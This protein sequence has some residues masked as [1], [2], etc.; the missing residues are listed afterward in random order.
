MNPK[1]TLALFNYCQAKYLPDSISAIISQTDPPDEILVFDDASTDNSINLLKEIPSAKFYF[2]KVNCGLNSNIKKS[3][4]IAEGDFIVFIAADDLIYPNFIKE[5]RNI[6]K[7]FSN[8]G[9]ICSDCV[10]FDDKLPYKY[11]IFRFLPFV[12]PQIFSPKESIDLFRKT[13]FSLLSHTCIY[14]RALLK[15]F[16]GYDDKLMSLADFFLNTQIALRYPIAY[17]PSPSA[18][19]RVVQNS[20]GQSFR[21]SWEKRKKI[22]ERLFELVYI[23]SDSEFRKAFHRARLMS[24]VGMYAIYYVICNPK[25]WFCLP[26]LLIKNWKLNFYKVFCLVLRREIPTLPVNPEIGKWP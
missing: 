3:I 18:A 22:Y 26:S 8:L 7:E 9:L 6:L 1:I 16:G 13:G 23:E 14:N 2:N 17:I 10:F 24:F 12:T 5:R 25:Y 20:Y 19:I 4:E 21:K 11:K 15:K